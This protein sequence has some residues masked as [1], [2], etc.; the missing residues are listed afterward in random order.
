KR[1]LV[2]VGMKN[3]PFPMK[4]VS[5]VKAEGQFTVANISISARIMHE[6]ESGWIDRFIEIVHKHRDRIGTKTLKTNIKD[7]LKKLHASTIRIDFDYPY[8]IEKL[9]PVSREKCL[10]RYMCTYSAK[11][12][13]VENKARI[14]FKM[15]VPAITTYPVSDPERAGGL[16]GQLSVAE[17]EVESQRDIYPEDLVKI[18]DKHALVPVY[19]FLTKEDQG[20]VI[21]KIHSEKK[22]SVVMTDEIKNELMHNSAI[23][24]Y[25]IRCSNFGML[26]SYSTV[27]STEK[28]MWIPSVS[29][30]E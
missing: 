12:S 11:I 16:F 22:T 10:V 25:S 6:F 17:I 9:T 19:S 20:F 3:L 18:V 30:S 23:N 26:H 21:Q 2:D 1:Y 24:W 7:Y 15:Q 14:I 8:F 4:V 28:S 27:I 13:S 29:Y 5:K